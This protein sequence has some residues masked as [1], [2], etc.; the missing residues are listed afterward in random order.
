MLAA[1]FA[2]DD[3][4][5]WFTSGGSE[6][7]ESAMKILWQYWRAKGQPDKTII[8]S[9]QFSYH[10]GTLGATSVSGS[11]FRRAPFEK[12]LHDWPRIAACYPYREQT[13][14]ESDIDYGLRTA[15]ELEQAILAAGPD[16]VAA[17][18]AEPVVGATLGAAPAIDG[19]F[20]EIR[21]I[22]DEYD[23]LFVADEVM[24]GSGRCGTFFAHETDAILPDLVTIAKGL[25]GG[26]QPIG[27]VIARNRIYE[28]LREDP[29][30]FAHGHTYIGHPVACAAGVAVQRAL[31]EGLLATVAPK[32]ERLIEILRDNFALHPRVGDIRGRGLFVGMEFVADR[33][34]KTAFPREDR[35]P[36]KLKNAAMQHGLICY[37]GGGTVDGRAGAHLLLA[38]PFIA[39]EAHFLLLAERLDEILKSVFPD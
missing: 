7:N 12:V 10:G 29:A 1:R 35:I 3:A 23:V 34:S 37:P 27:A 33:D 8:I 4:K 9:R 22:C 20:R 36:Q 26:Y 2:E 18:I 38:P 14:G 13:A 5:V 19:Y 21:R 15:R 25:G 32:G 31:D 39:E 24:C 16:K 28:G 6:S 11:H 30:G 17:F